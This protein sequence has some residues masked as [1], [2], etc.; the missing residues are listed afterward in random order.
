MRL[1]LGKSL[2]F[3][4]RSIL[5]RESAQFKSQVSNLLEGLTQPAG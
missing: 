4:D 5:V 1:V 2:P 3:H